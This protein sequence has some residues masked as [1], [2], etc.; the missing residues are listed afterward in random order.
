MWDH[1]M[2]APVQIAFAINAP[3]ILLTI[4]AVLSLAVL[5]SLLPFDAS[6]LFYLSYGVGVFVFWR[7]V[8]VWLDRRRN[9]MPPS[10]R[11][12]HPTTAE[13]AAYVGGGV[14]VVFGL[15]MVLGS[16]RHYPILAVGFLLWPSLVAIVLLLEA[17]R[18]RR[19]ARAAANSSQS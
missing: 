10:G 11:P 12:V 7:F 16:S 15:L 6:W 18:S 3:A 4:P 5:L 17:R 14:C 1:Y 13:A 2:P 19:L 8:G 9:L